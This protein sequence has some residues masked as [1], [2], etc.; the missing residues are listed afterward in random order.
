MEIALAR[1]RDFII[2]P[3][4]ALRLW[5]HILVG[6]LFDKDK[7][8]RSDIARW[9]EIY[10]RPAPTNLI[11]FIYEFTYFM[12]YKKE[13]RNVFYVRIW[14]IDKLISWL[15]PPLESL[16][17]SSRNIGPGLFIQ[18][19]IAT[20]VSAER[21]GANCWINQQVTVGFS[22]AT[23]RPTIGDNVK[24]HA[25]AKLVGKIIVGDN[26]V[27][28]LN[29]VVISNVPANSTVFGVPGRH[30]WNRNKREQS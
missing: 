4:S 19:G 16:E 20:L 6:S 5:P 18:H 3:I 30:M 28:G 13:Y 2:L 7:L 29:T 1:V 12:T 25:G 27:I 9:A 21:I 26:A 17:I 24:I 8:T 11:S 14:P 23:D 15:C 10:G 22:N